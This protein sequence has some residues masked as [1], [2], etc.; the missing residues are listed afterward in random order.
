MDGLGS[1]NWWGF[2]PALDLLLGL[3]AYAK[4]KSVCRDV[5]KGA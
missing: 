1:I 4:D 3:D 5:S 2:T